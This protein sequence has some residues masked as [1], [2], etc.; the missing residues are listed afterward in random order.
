[1]LGPRSGGQIFVSGRR[2]RVTTDLAGD[3][4]TS[5]EDLVILRSSE[6]ARTFS[7]RHRTLLEFH[8]VSKLGVS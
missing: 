5:L 1:M 8:R 3:R 7:G 6:T 2:G 4:H